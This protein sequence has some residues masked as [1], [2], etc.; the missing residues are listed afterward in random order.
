MARCLPASRW[1]SACGS[2]LSITAPLIAVPA[3]RPSS[4]E[5][6]AA[7][8][9]ATVASPSRSRAGVD[10]VV[11]VGP[12]LMVCSR[13]S[14]RR[15]VSLGEHSGVWPQPWCPTTEMSESEH[16]AEVGLDPFEPT[17]GSCMWDLT[18]LAWQDHLE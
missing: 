3:P 18:G 4:R 15:A 11:L 10:R 6:V 14:T 13:G 9:P 1:G 7:S 8:R 2:T 12:V 5:A 17:E 16:G